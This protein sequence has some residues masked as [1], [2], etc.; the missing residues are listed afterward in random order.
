MTP[1]F[2]E[3]GPTIRVSGGIRA[4]S[5]KGAIGESW[6]SKRFISVA[7]VPVSSQPL[8]PASV[9]QPT[10]SSLLSKAGGQDLLHAQLRAAGTRPG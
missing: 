1:R 6:W 8:L 10:V 5:T 7:S 3:Y 4:Q 9:A 2:S